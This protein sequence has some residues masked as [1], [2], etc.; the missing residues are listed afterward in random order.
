VSY[1]LVAHL[2]F[3]AA[4]VVQ[5]GTL[6]FVK[7]GTGCSVFRGTGPRGLRIEFRESAQPRAGSPINALGLQFRVPLDAREMDIIINCLV[8]NP[9]F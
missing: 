5:G 1:R 6:A 7:N 2:E 3:V 4:V 8:V 9:G